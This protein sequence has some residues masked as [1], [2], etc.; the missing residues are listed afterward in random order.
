[1]LPVTALR[2]AM[3]S[4]FVA[5]DAHPADSST[6]I[7]NV[8]FDAERKTILTINKPG[9]LSIVQDPIDNKDHLLVSSFQLLG[10]D[11]LFSISSWSKGLSSPDQLQISTLSDS[12]TWPNEARTAG[13]GLFPTNGILVSGGFLVPG[14]STGAVTFVP[15]FQPNAAYPLTTAKKG[16]FYHRTEEWDV[17]QDGFKDIVTARSHIPM[18]GTPQGELL[19]LENPGSKMSAPLPWQEHVIA[20]GPDVHFRI[21]PSEMG[22]SL[23]II[24][25]EFSKKRLTAYRQQPSG[26]FERII[27]DETLGSAFDVQLADLNSDKQLDLVV[28]NHEAD[29]KASVFGYEFDPSSLKI[30][31]RHV[32]LAGIETRQK[33]FK[34]ASPG[35]V[36]T[37]WPKNRSGIA[38]Q[39]PWLLIS[40]DG[41]QKAHILVPTDPV[42]TD[43]WTYREHILWN[44][45]STVGQSTLGDVDKDGL[46][47]L[48]IPAYD[49]NQLAVFTIVPR[50][51]GDH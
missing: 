44:P 21:L 25:T 14:K 46:L 32:L 12:I 29:E 9:Y 22:E 1:M 15:W 27:L 39:K 19:W 42:S 2:I 47:E 41:S 11:Q 38:T 10:K 31:A 43:N 35:P 51:G 37:F 6:R 34:A 7:S 5:P 20:S 26:K 33:A 4:L 17:N 36:T 18:M 24:A 13:D 45:K 49:A 40:G 30:K 3:L 50:H 48:F 28:T 23:T 8:D 16:W